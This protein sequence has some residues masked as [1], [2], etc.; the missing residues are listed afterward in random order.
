[1]AKLLVIAEHRDGKL[2]DATME[3]CRIAKEIAPGL[4]LEPAAAVFAKDDALAKEVANYIPEVF[5]VA[6][7]AVEVYTADGYTQAVKGVVES[8]DVKGVL[9]AHT[10]DG[11]DFAAKAAMA[12][13]AGIVSNCNKAEVDG[14]KLVLTRNIF[15]GKIQETKSIKTDKFVVSFEKGAYDP[16]E[17]GAAGSVTAVSVSFGEIRTKVKEVIETSTGGVDITNARIIVGGGRGLKDGDKFKEVVVPLAQKLGG[18]YAG[19]RPVI[20]S[21]WI[22]AS[23]QVGQS[24]KTVTPDLYLALGISGAVQH[25]AGM[26]GSKCIVAV[27]KDPE[28]P[29]FNIATYGIVGD[30][31]EVVPAFSAKL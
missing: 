9:I 28:A 25:V 2:S 29:I 20:D 24:G 7:P 19:S 14:G 27:N 4:G 22:E 1:M 30:L 8:Q 17:A 18:E 5:A 16:A 6:D 13:D 3:L 15:N 26:K 31:F 11:V 23:R 12:I 10:Y 21:G